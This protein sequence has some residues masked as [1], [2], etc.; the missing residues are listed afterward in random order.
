V[1]LGIAEK[2][3]KKREISPGRGILGDGPRTT[4]STTAVTVNALKSK[5][6]FQQPGSNEVSPETFTGHPSPGW[7]FFWPHG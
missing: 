6:R 4:F 7:P 5:E 3:G 2:Q 1:S